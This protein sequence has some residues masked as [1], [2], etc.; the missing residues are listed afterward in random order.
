MSENVAKFG[1]TSMA[2]PGVVA[3]I[4]M[5]NP[6][7]WPYVV[8]SAPGTDPEHKVKV[9]DSLFALAAL[10]PDTSE[11]A[12]Q[13]G[14]IVDR[15]DEIYR[16]HLGKET[17]RLND[18][19]LNLLERNRYR[20][21][22]QSALGEAASADYF[23]ALTG[24]EAFVPMLN[25]KIDFRDF[26][27]QLNARGEVDYRLSIAATRQLPAGVIIPG[28]FGFLPTGGLSTLRRG[29]SDRT[30]G[31]VAASLGLPYDNFTDVQGIFAADPRIVSDPRHRP[32]LTFR[33]VREAAVGGSG[34]L[35]G[36]TIAD[37]MTI[38]KHTGLK[39]GIQIFVRDTFHPDGMSTTIS[40]HYKGEK[41]RRGIQLISART[42]H[43][44]SV[45]DPS[46]SNM[47]GWI[48][49]LTDRMQ[50]ALNI[51][52]MLT[53]RDGVTFFVDGKDFVD[54]EE[55]A[56]NN[57]IE[58]M[59]AVG[60]SIS[61]ID[62]PR[63]MSVITLVGE[64]LS[65]GNNFRS[66]T[67]ATRALDDAGINTFTTHHHPNTP[68]F[69]ITTGIGGHDSGVPRVDRQ[70]VRVLYNAFLKDRHDKTESK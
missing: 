68:A 55:A 65:S 44:I 54:G 41:R 69:V 61:R 13:A 52:H 34:V 56:L 59:R 9:T 17:G 33:E 67:R 5:D 15:F 4:L 70:A 57:A 11:W 22:I 23:A 62:N 53:S 28:Y 19:F 35:E 51:E 16:P 60:S 21:H 38:T 63:P 42:L 18:R 47:T 8:V 46:S 64:D 30:G 27:I 48:A 26:P 2:Q 6:E 3:E 58:S 40:P 1:G 14:A 45:Y 43:A 39:E 49:N 25:A 36:N 66:V 31:I 32:N 29:G 12:E 7:R 20:H 10:E 24:M 50:P 37:I